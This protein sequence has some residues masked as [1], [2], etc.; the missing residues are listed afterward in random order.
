M[1]IVRTEHVVQENEYV[2]EVTDE[3]R[4]ELQE[5]LIARG[6]KIQLTDKVITFVMDDVY[7]G[8]EDEIVDEL[9]RE[10]DAIEN[11]NE[12]FRLYNWASCARDIIESF[13]NEYIWDRDYEVLDSM[14]DYYETAVTET[15]FDYSK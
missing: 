7:N 14:V 2:L 12:T 5:I 9:D 1:K 6:S 3:I 11:T 15:D 10:L 13:L 4:A 8:L